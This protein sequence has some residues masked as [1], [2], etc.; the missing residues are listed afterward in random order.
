MPGRTP[1]TSSMGALASRGLVPMRA[2]QL[3]SPRIS[4][5]TASAVAFG[6][7]GF[8]LLEAE[9]LPEPPAAAAPAPPPFEPQATRLTDSITRTIQFLI[10]MAGSSR[11][12]GYLEL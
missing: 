11:A 8:A 7:R 1:S 2:G 4:S 3:T 9:L 6:E 5:A 12:R 10:C